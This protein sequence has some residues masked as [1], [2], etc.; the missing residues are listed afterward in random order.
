M[1]GAKATT[2]LAGRPLVAYP[3]DALLSVC[4]RVAVACKAGTELPEL[5]AGVERWDEPAEPR[6]PAAAIV[7]A[8]ER[9]GEPVLVCAADMPFVTSELC[10]RLAGELRPGVRAAVARAGGRLQPLVAAYAPDAAGLMRAAA[11][12]DPLTRTVESLAPVVVDTDA[13]LVFNVNT[14]EDLAEAERRLST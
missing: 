2:P 5:P 6:H 10:T 4:E 7:L 11:P 12:D 8:L 14:P 3:I 1:G 13:D 9:A